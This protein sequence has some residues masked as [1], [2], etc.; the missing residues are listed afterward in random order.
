MLTGQGFSDQRV[1]DKI[2]HQWGNTSKNRPS[3]YFQMIRLRRCMHVEGQV[4]QTQVLSVYCCCCCWIFASNE[5]QPI[6]VSRIFSLSLIPNSHLPVLVR[7]N[8]R[9][10]H[11]SLINY[12]TSLRWRRFA[13]CSRVVALKI[14]HFY[15]FV[16]T[17]GPDS[18]GKASRIKRDSCLMRV[19]TTMSQCVSTCYHHVARVSDQTDWR[20][21][22][23]FI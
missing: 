9:N 13:T 23:S 1:V 11:T 4:V 10:H 12:K 17:L 6:C 15:S 21:I 3:K 20:L 7:I 8:S 2:N 22:L 19:V 18:A 16:W 14:F 5:Y